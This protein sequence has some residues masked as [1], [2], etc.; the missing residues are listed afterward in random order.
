M[1]SPDKPYKIYDQK[2]RRSDSWNPLDYARDFDF[3]KTFAENFSL[4]MNEVPRLSMDLIN[5]ENSDYCNY[6]GDDKNC[7][8]DIA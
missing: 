4:L 6:C 3:S 5:C 7:Y 1:Y 8:I 2:V